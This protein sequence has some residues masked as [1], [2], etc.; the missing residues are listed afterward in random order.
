LV[1]E[2]TVVSFGIPEPDYVRPTLSAAVLVQVTFLLP[3][4]VEQLA[5]VNVAGTDI[6]MFDEGVL[7][8]VVSEMADPTSW[9]K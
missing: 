1:I 4:V 9:V 6:V 5:S 8:N 2:L 7:V 3:E